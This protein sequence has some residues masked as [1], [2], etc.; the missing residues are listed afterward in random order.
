MGSSMCH[1]WK[2]QLEVDHGCPGHCWPKVY[3]EMNGRKPRYVDDR[4]MEGVDC[5]MN[6]RSGIAGVGY[7]RLGI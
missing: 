5:M 6:T 4:T 2:G 3:I 1:V 7:M